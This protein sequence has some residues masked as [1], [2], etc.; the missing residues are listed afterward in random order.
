ML[1]DQTV[2]LPD[3]AQDPRSA[4]TA[5]VLAV[6]GVI[7]PIG[8]GA[9]HGGPPRRSRRAAAATAVAWVTIALHTAFLVWLATRVFG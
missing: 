2:A 6:T 5:L 9:V 8:G 1:A 4:T 7:G 3:P